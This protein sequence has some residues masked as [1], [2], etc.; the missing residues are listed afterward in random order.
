MPQ[1]T[2]AGP[3]GH[4]I[5][6]RYSP[7]ERDNAP[8]ALIL[9][10]HPL[11]GGTM[12]NRVVYEV[13]RTF[14]QN[15]FSTLRFNFRGVGKS[16]GECKD[17][18]DALFD[19]ALALDWLQAENPDTPQCW[20]GGFSFGAR[21]AL[22]LVMRRPEITGFVAVAPPAN[23]HDFSFLSPCPASGLFLHGSED[24]VVPVEAF[25]ELVDR[26]G[27]QNDI[28]VEHD[29]IE[30]ADHFFKDKTQEISRRLDKYLQKVTVGVSPA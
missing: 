9:H 11:H 16:R 19:A 5:E 2:F 4:L 13:Y 24:T 6:G 30:G 29:V 21:V 28:D 12:N 17:E 3:G 26:L 7:A 25:R 27:D 23:F 14:R 20:I 8:I 22:E 18:N 1:V 15:G 10:P